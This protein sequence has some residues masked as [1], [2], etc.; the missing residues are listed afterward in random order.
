[1]IW[2]A[3]P[4]FRSGM[5]AVLAWSV[6]SLTV[7]PSH[8]GPINS[9]V[10]F[11]PRKG[12]SILRLQY[13][14]T[15]AHGSAD[16]LHA[17]TTGVRATFIHGVRE[18]FALIVSAPYVHREVDKLDADGF[19]LELRHDGIADITVLGKYRFWQKDSG[20]LES[21]RWAVLGGINVRSGDSKFS[22]DSY[23][24]IV[25]A[26][27]S[28][29]RDRAHLDADLVYQFNTAG[30]R[31]GHDTLRYD[32]AYSFRLFPAVFR[33][34]RPRAID[35]IAELNGRYT[36]DG[37]HELFLSP[38]LQF[39]TERW[40]IEASVQFPVAQELAGDAM[41]IDYRVVFGVRFHW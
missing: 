12:G 41:E 37:S 22:S 24:P 25:G 4:P 15:E 23:D 31:A 6:G 27:Y 3:R 36:T 17:R 1:M 21:V 18:D 39:A 9:D 33:T 38:G 14:Y 11:T 16:I 20:P 5:V 29:R 26:V 8:A 30:G 35:V 13:A 32:L 10:A 19:G 7:A 40:S 2:P 28:W 34:E